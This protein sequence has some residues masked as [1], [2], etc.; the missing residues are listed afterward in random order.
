MRKKLFLIDGTAMIYRAYYALIRN[1]LRN[2]KGENTSAIF[3]TIN[4][5]LK[6]VEN[7]EVS[8]IIISF[9]RKEKTFR[10]EIDTNYKANRPPAPDELINQIEPIKEFFKLINLPEVSVA[11]YEADD[12]LATLANQY[13][14]QYEIIIVSADKDFSQLVSSEISL[15][16]P[17]K[18]K[19]Y[20]PENIEEKYGILPDQFIDYLAICGDSADN[21]PGVKGVGAKGAQKL[22]EK[23]I[24]LEN[25]Y[26]NIDDISSKSLKNKLI[27]SKENAFLSKNLATIKLDVPISEVQNFSFNPSNFSKLYSFLEKYELHSIMKKLKLDQP[28]FEEEFSFIQE[29]KTVFQSVLVT[30]E[31]QF[32]S[33]LNLLKGVDEISIDTETTSKDSLK[34]DLVGISLAFDTTKAYYISLAHE[35]S[36][37][38]DKNFVLSELEKVLT[39]KLLIAH[40]FKYDYQVFKRSGWTIKNDVF[41]TIIAHYL[42]HP[43][44][45]HALDFCSEQ[46]LECEMTPISDLIGKRKKQI[47]FDL[48]DQKKAADYAAE[49]A[50]VTF[51]IYQIL[52]NDLIR[53]DL[54]QLYTNIEIPLLYVLSNMEEN[55]VFID[56][57]IL[58]EI[59]KANQ[60]RIGELTQKIYQISGSQFNLNSTQQLGKVLF[61]D[62]QIPPVKKTKTGYSTDINVLEKLSHKYP[63]A[64]FLIEYR[65]LTKLESTYIQALP[66]LIHSETNRVH[67]SFNQTVASTGRLS[68]S[69]P[70]LQNIPIRTSLGKEIRKSFTVEN[71]DSILIAADYSQIELRLLAI[72]SEDDKMIHAFQ[73]KL[74]IHRQTASLIFD[75]EAKSVTSDQR[76]YAKVINFGLIYGMGANRISQEL[77]ISRKEAEL[78]VENYFNQFPTIK[79]FMTESV[80]K[81]KKLGYAETISGRKLLL[82]NIYSSNKRFRSEAERVAINM[83]IQGSAADI[84]KIAMIEL[85]RSIKT[86][87][88]LEMIIQVHD[89]LVFEVN[90]EYKIQAIQ[91][92][93]DKMESALPE[94]LRE[95]VPLVVDIGTGKNWFEAH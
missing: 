15:Y 67:S 79:H 90:H 50:F 88:S 74:D 45:R 91:L 29:K 42:L 9:D 92:I 41:D 40:N 14:N 6:L 37:N 38:L 70:N 66:E 57:K 3:G 4:M 5:F 62:L 10:H 68:S 89:E 76:R 46:L 71:K 26:E 12:V 35:M 83:P 27:E 20:N 63:I 75:V 1:P 61:E 33:L 72:L 21:I 30:K 17:S 55:G 84:I 13:K 7:F 43:T 28:T 85:D 19:F 2:S 86:V 69:N 49:D 39:G 24:T 8:N 22:L 11:G 31:S 44:Q 52:K 56:K 59:S 25:I 48:V 53:N 54:W 23:Y 95:K 32:V 87:P 64:A 80:E 51:Q 60:K 58:H 78:F 47:T 94:E 93:K 16:D 81:V 73:N 36:E 18:N 82:P 65:Q 77:Q 34:A